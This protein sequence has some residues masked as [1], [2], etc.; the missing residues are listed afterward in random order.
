M[1]SF[2]CWLILF[3]IV[4]KSVSLA[5]K[6]PCPLFNATSTPATSRNKGYTDVARF[7]NKFFAVGT[8]GRIDCITESGEKIRVDSSCTNNLHCAFSNEELLITAGDHGNLYHQIGK[9][10]KSAE[11]RTEK[12]IHGIPIKNGCLLQ[13]PT[14]ELYLLQKKGYPGTSFQPTS[15]EISCR[16]PPA[17]PASLEL[18]TLVK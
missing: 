5:S 17:I 2:L 1:P 3:M 8:D 14:E 7:H 11:S 16:F 15:K 6:R 9:N 13:V 12:S 10:F 18:Q 4:D